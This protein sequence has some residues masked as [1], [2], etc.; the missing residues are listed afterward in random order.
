MYT[1][2]LRKESS[3]DWNFSHCFRPPFL[4]VINTGFSLMG[5]FSRFRC[6]CLVY[7]CLPFDRHIT[8]CWRTLARDASLLESIYERCL[9]ILARNIHYEEKLDNKSK[10]VLSRTAALLPLTVSLKSIKYTSCVNIDIVWHVV[11]ALLTFISS[12]WFRNHNSVYN[13]LLLFKIVGQEMEHR[14]LVWNNSTLFILKSSKLWLSNFFFV[15]LQNFIYFLS[16]Q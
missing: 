6:H 9:D 13:H 8:E 10:Q 11:F 16:H 12:Y 5:L 7:N 14:K 1:L 4:H 3:L 15:I 2:C